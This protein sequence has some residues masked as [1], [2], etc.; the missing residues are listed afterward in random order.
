MRKKIESKDNPKTQHTNLAKYKIEK[1][2][3]IDLSTNLSTLFMSTIKRLVPV[4]YLLMLG[5]MIFEKGYYFATG[6]IF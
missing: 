1:R 2:A 5:R 4:T 6:T 3:R